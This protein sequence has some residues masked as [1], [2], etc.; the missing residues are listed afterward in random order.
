M[1]NENKISIVLPT[2]RYQ[3]APELSSNISIN[4]D[5]TNKEVIEYDRIYNLSLSE[6]FDSE[7]QKSE[8]FNLSGKF[9][10]IFSNSMTG[11]TAYQPF[12]NSL[13]YISPE[14]YRQQ[15]SASNFNGKWGGFPSYSEFDLMRFDANTSGYTTG[16]PIHIQ[17][18]DTQAASYNWNYYITY[19][20]DNDY[21][22]TLVNYNQYYTQWTVGDGIP[23]QTSRFKLNGQKLILFKCFVKHGLN[24]GESVQLSSIYTNP[25]TFTTTNLFE[26]YYLGNE[27]YGS[28]EY[29]FSIQD[30]GYLNNFLSPGTIGTF[31]R[32]LD[33]DN[34]SET[35]SKYYIRKHKV[36]KPKEDLVLAT[37]GFEQEIHTEVTKYFTQSL[38]PNFTSRTATKEGGNVYTIST[39]TNTSINGLTDNLGR[40]VS[41]LYYTIINR[42]YFGWFNPPVTNGQNSL[43]EGW[44]FN[45]DYPSPSSYWNR[46]PSNSYSDTSIGVSSYSRNIN[47]S[48]Y[49]FY[50]N[51][52]LNVGDNL[53]GD[54][55][56]WNDYEDR[57]RV[58]S[59]NYHKF[60]F[61]PNFFEV[62][63]NT[64]TYVANPNGYYYKPHYEFTLRVFSDYIETAP[65][66]DNVEGIPDYAFFSTN[67][68][69]YRWRDL[70][71]YGYIDSVGTGVDNPYNNGSHYI[72]KNFFFKII[73]EGSNYSIEGAEY[74]TLPNI[75]D[76]E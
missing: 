18:T 70:Y 54:F 3:G 20:Y 67:N 46:N 65:V 24:V 56:E 12:Q 30:I 50:Y 17:F 64:T 14:Y 62:S 36:I 60:V 26:V 72:H 31:K 16:Q 37:A 2:K 49:T 40:P 25:S 66:T 76:C 6:L 59:E 29:Y 23:F 8:N 73:P 15:S 58:I 69:E 68:Q 38:T 52:G 74:I 71:P 22:K 53:N 13:F 4:L 44:E 21:T 63:G 43:K 1:N 61:N 47:G 48:N 5:S 10:V 57:E 55:C 19:A 51:N 11:E 75:D 7:R 39:Q 45:L 28:E 33:P 35:T 42:G 41:K 9:T 34:V 32:V 27:T